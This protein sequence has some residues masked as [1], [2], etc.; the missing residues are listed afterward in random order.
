MRRR[1]GTPDES[2]LTWRR[3]VKFAR[4]LAYVMSRPIVLRM[5]KPTALGV[6]RSLFKPRVAR[7]MVSA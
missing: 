1:G 7:Q 6:L 2:M 3:P 4:A 5:K